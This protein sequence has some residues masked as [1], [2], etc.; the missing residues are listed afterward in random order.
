MDYKEII[1]IIIISVNFRN[2]SGYYSSKNL[3]WLRYMSNF[4]AS[5]FFGH[6]VEIYP[7]SF[8]HF[9]FPLTHKNNKYLKEKQQHFSWSIQGFSS[10]AKTWRKEKKLAKI[11]LEIVK[12][13]PISKLLF[14]KYLF[15]KKKNISGFLL[16]RNFLCDFFVFSLCLLWHGNYSFQ[17]L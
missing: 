13:L 8:N 12:K 6:N 2:K 15:R 10:M 7:N 17:L 14:F 1:I 3:I 16:K 11:K 9:S 5:S 4:V